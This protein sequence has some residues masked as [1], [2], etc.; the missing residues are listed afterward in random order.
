MKK[1]LSL[2]LLLPFLF[3]YSCSDDDDDNYLDGTTW[4][5][6]L[7]TNDDISY[8]CVLSFTKNSEAM[9]SKHSKQLNSDPLE[10]NN[11][12]PVVSFGCIYSRNGDEIS[13]VDADGKPTKAILNTSNNT[14]TMEGDLVLK[15]E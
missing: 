5:S 2:L 4:Q 11:F 8:F 3:V 1:F 14:I 7:I 13:C 10:L 6:D 12:I 15:K 9:I